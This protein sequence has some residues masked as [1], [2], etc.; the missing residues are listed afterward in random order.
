MPKVLEV[1]YLPNLCLTKEI[2]VIWIVHYVC[3]YG[4]YQFSFLL[5]C[6]II[7]RIVRCKITRLNSKKKNEKNRMK[8]AHEKDFVIYW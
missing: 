1:D 6:D 5:F 2:S 8:R 7:D 3:I 4:E